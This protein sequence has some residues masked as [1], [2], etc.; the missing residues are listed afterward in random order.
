MNQNNVGKSFDDLINSV[1]QA[2]QTYH[3]LFINVAKLLY[4]NIDTSN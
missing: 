4:G 1:T 3:F 2:Y